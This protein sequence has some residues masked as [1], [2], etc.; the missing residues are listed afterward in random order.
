MIRPPGQGPRVLPSDLA[1]LVQA[2]FD[3]FPVQHAVAAVDPS[4][5]P[6]V[7]S[8][9]A[10]IVV[11]VIS[12]SLV[13]SCRDSAARFGALWEQGGMELGQRRALGSCPFPSL[14]QHQTATNEDGC[15][16]DEA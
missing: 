8:S 7:H 13:A 1:Y 9:A 10:V 3:R 4:H 14:P 16:N 2:Y 6:Q 15:C 5:M 12:T 11:S